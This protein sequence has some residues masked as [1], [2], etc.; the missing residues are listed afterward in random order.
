MIP[1]PSI[2]R[3]LTWEPSTVENSRERTEALEVMA[4][5]AELWAVP[6]VTDLKEL[7]AFYPAEDYHRD[8]FATNPQQGY[9]K[10]VIAPKVVKFR[11]QFQE[12]LKAR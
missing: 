11:K 7:E 4:A 8:Y 5:M 3:G 2:A 6:I 1:Q 9:C 12:K 10:M